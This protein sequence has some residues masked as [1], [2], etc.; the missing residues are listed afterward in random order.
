MIL[1]HMYSPHQFSPKSKVCFGVHS[2]RVS[3]V[4]LLNAI[5]V[6]SQANL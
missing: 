1:N 6:L 3:K 5:Q 4:D 2:I